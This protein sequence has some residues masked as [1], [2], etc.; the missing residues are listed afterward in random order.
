MGPVACTHRDVCGDETLNDGALGDG[1]GV[2]GCEGRSWHPDNTASLPTCT[3]TRHGYP[4]Y[5]ENPE[6]KGVFMFD[7]PD[8]C[9]NKLSPNG[10][11]V[12]KEARECADDDGPDDCAGPWH[13]AA[14]FDGCSNSPRGTYPDD[15]TVPGVSERYFY[16]THAECCNATFVYPSIDECPKTNHCPTGR[17]TPAPVSCPSENKWHR[18]ADANARTC[19]NDLNYPKAWNDP[20]LMWDYLFDTPEQCCARTANQEEPCIVVDICTGPGEALELPATPITM[21]QPEL[22]KAT[23]A[24]EP[25]THQP[26]VSC[27][28]VT[29]KKQCS[30]KQEC[31]WDATIDSC[32]DAA[33]SSLSAEVGPGENSQLQYPTLVEEQAMTEPTT[34]CGGIEKKKSCTKDPECNWDRSIDMCVE[35][36]VSAPIT[37]GST[38]SPTL[39][40]MKRQMEPQPTRGC[41]LI[42]RKKSCGKDPECVWDV[43]L[44]SCVNTNLTPG[45]GKQVVSVRGDDDCAEKKYHPTSVRI[46]RCS[47]SD[48][49]PSV[50]ASS[51]DMR[52][53]YFFTVG[54]DCCATFYS[55]GPCEVVNVC[56]STT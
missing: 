4:P 40:S 42:F 44:N 10:D 39:S 38:E 50:W 7:T 16:E 56:S 8:E 31:T 25:A 37:D 11:C 5:W 21:S 12:M 45:K 9:C 26:P 2:S 3:N 34:R 41:G 49:F 22:L 23:S 24:D 48:S 14:D 51:P 13:P 32:A 17:P 15:W 18:D 19:T 27:R 1:H 47:N 20:F 28:G 33:L 52:K 55:D 30:K 6:M 53:K 43:S 36:T 54:D 29:K 46:R 35:A